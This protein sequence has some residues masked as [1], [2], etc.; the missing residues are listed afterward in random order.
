M[1]IDMVVHIHNV[2]GGVVGCISA[3][4]NMH[5]H[6]H[7]CL[8]AALHTSS[9]PLSVCISAHIIVTVVC[10]HLCT[11]HHC[12]LSSVI[13]VICASPLMLSSS[14]CIPA[15][16]DLVCASPA[17]LLLEKPNWTWVNWLHLVALGCWTGCDQLI[18]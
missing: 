6:C 18:Q 11:C 8:C 5:H 14:G 1:S 3:T 16:I 2:I 7:H 9:L 17:L 12:H 4:L 15:C 13:L 10:V